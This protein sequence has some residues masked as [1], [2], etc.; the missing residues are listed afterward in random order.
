M[1]QKNQVELNLG[2]GAEGEARSA[3]AREPEARPARACPERPAVAGPSMEDVVERENLK[4]ALARVKRNKGTAGIDGM[5]VDDLSAY[6]KEHWPTVRVQLLEGIYKPQ[7][8]W[9]VEIPKPSGGMRLLGIPTVLDRFIQQA[10]MQVLQADWDGTFSETSFGFRP[11]RSAHQAVERAQTYIASGHAIVV[12]IDLEKFFD[13]VNH[14]I[15][16]GLVAKRVADKRILKLIRGFLTAGAMEGGLVSP[17]EEGTP[18]GGPLSPLLSN[19]M[20]DVLDKEL[21]KRGH[22]F[23]RYADDCNIYVRSQKAGERVL[24]G[25]ERFIEKRL[26]LKVNKAK[27]AVAKPSVRKFLGFSYTSGRKP[28]RRVAPQAIARFKARIREL[29]RRTRGRSLAQI[30]KELSVYLIGWRGYFGFCQTPS[31]LRALEEWIRRR[32]RAIAWKQWKCGPARFAE[33]RRCGVGR[34]LAARTAGSPRGPWRLASSPALTTAM[35]IA[36]FGSLGLTSI[37]E[38]RHA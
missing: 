21:E 14:D 16:M 29:T 13:R 32:L 10:V 30:V 7:P 22:R 15:L 17:T 9:R 26:K 38:L 35:P 34:D 5:N 33:L 25:I 18:Q 20:L 24:A 27:S 4:K 37:T 36:F 23:V 31:V 11:K 1:R 3:A 2:T 6:L 12:D 19:L 8:V 28:R